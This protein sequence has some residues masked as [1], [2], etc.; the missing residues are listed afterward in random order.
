MCGI[1]GYVGNK[2]VVDVILKGLKRLEYRG[3]DSSGLAFFRDAQIEV[4]KAKGKIQEVE[5][6]TADVAGLDARQGGI[7]HTRWATHGKPDQ[8]NAHPH[9]V[10]DIVLVHNGIIENYREILDE[11]RS[12][13]AKGLHQLQRTLEVRVT[14]GDVNDQCRAPPRCELGESAGKGVR[15]NSH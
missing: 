7:G 8:I 13:L 12:R 4:M 2:P 15:R 5:R 9:Q 14:C 1:I 11:V 3:Y 6:L 10:G